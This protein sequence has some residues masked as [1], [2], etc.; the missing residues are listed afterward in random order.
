MTMSETSAPAS[1]TAGTG[2]APT[3][4][5][6]VDRPARLDQLRAATDVDG[7]VEASLGEA[8]AGPAPA[9]A[10]G[11]GRGQD[12]EA[13]R[14]ARDVDLGDRS[15]SRKIIVAV[16][17]A[18]VVLVGVV[19]AVVMGGSSEPEAA[20]PPPSSTGPTTSAPKLVAAPDVVAEEQRQAS[21]CEAA[22]VYSIDDLLR[23]G[24]TVAADPDRFLAAYETLSVNVPPELR[25]LVDQMG[26]L[27]RRVAAAVKAGTITSASDVQVWLALM[28]APELDAWVGP[29][30]ELAPKLAQLCA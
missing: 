5:M 14:T 4:G 18:A 6:T 28:P 16:V 22:A 27:T 1:G 30:Q 20:A 29:Q 17:V 26:P 9:A 25:P 24:E 3:G 12:G 21:M 19:A 7:R 2:G 23:L 10:T 11:D 8:T 15:G 13:P